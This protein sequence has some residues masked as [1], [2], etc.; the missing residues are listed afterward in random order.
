MAESKGRFYNSEIKSNFDATVK[1][2]KNAAN[3]VPMLQ[4][5][6]AK[7]LLTLASLDKNKRMPNKKNPADRKKRGGWFLT[8]GLPEKKE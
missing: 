8:L 4:N 6:V 7:E 2:P 5:Q 3:T 1:S